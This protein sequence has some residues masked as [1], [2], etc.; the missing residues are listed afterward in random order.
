MG[1]A[2]PLRF[3]LMLAG[4]TGLSPLMVGRSA[5][6]ARLVEVAVDDARPADRPAVALVSGEAGIGKT[7]LLRELA[8]LLPPGR[9]LVAGQAEPGSLGRPWE[10]V[11]SVLGGALPDDDGR[12]GDDRAGAVAA[13]VLARLPAG[14]VVVFEDL[15]W[16]DAESVT[17]FER[18]AA[19]V[20]PAVLLVG[21]YRPEELSR[22]RPGGEMLARLERRQDVLQIRLERLTR[23]EVGRFVH[24]I[25]GRALPAA[26]VGALHARTGGNPFFLE[27]LMSCC[28]GEPETLAD[29]PLPWSL[30]ELVA[31]Q[32]DGL[33]LDERKVVEAAAVLGRRAPFD[34]LAE[35]LG[36]P[37]DDLI[38]RLR[39]LVSQGVLVEEC[40]D[41]FTFRHAL[42]RDAV[43]GQLLG[44]ERRRLHACALDVL[45]AN[46]RSDVAE[47]AAHAA[48]AG[49]Y[50]ELV[51]LARDGVG[52]YLASG[53]TYQAL[54]L[55]TAALAEAPDDRVLLAGAARASWLLGLDDEAAAHARRWYELAAREGSVEER[56]RACRL[57]GRASFELGDATTLWRLVDE[58]IALAGELPDGEERAAALA[59]VA[60]AHMLESRSDA[61]VEWADK[62]IAVA[63]A[64]DAKGIRAQ[65]L[66]ERASAIAMIPGRSAEG[67]IALREAALEAEAV[68]DDVLLTRA[69]NNLVDLSGLGSDEKR[70][71]IERLREVAVRAG[72][73][74]MSLLYAEMHAANWAIDVGDLAQARRHVDR[75]REMAP[76]AKPGLLAWHRGMDAL[77]QVEEGRPRAALDELA[78]PVPGLKPAKAVW[79]ARSTLLAAAALGNRDLAGPPLAVLAAPSEGADRDDVA[80]LVVTMVDVGPLLAMAASEVRTLLEPWLALAHEPA[81]VDDL[82]EALLASLDGRHDDVV[83]LVEAMEIGDVLAAPNHA[84]VHL[85][86]AR[87]LLALGRR[88]DAAVAAQAGRH[89]LEHWPG[90]RRDQLDAFLVRCLGPSGEA[91]DG[92][93]TRREREVAALVAEGLTNAELARRLYISPKTAAVHVSNI[94]MKLGMSSRAEVAAWVV[95]SGLDVAR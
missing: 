34:V 16:A 61:A 15:H 62:A 38:D 54:A 13:A 1:D 27:E 83:R 94:L 28:D 76:T 9:R 46:A 55:A 81:V 70:V 77:L 2:A 88:P 12:G 35:M 95:R 87:S 6:L 72:Y 79:G 82:A 78:K 56:S 50:D 67:A 68:G 80:G 52:T 51:E 59:F 45:R 21:T 43:E 19:T 25:Y 47:L 30:A 17:V 29:Q 22:R 3:P 57:L 65:A 40:D 91:V 4:R 93:L 32:L 14:G 48:R 7:R 8:A 23:N 92:E 84:A 10:L 90:W 33:T 42:V 86:L 37:E 20:P 18:L 49:H 26:V 63:E 24:A 44:R 31:R 5:A 41:E 66:V 36:T 60:Q 58:A 69:L 73:D 89:L 85:L 11:R 64:V 71:L 53:S 39:S 74:A 75:C